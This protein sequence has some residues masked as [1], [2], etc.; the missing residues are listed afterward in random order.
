MKFDTYVS[1]GT[2]ASDFRFLFTINEFILFL[3]TVK[4]KCNA[5]NTFCTIL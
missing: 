3:P 1:F 5:L 4:R 2:G